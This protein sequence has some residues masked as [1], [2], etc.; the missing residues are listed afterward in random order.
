MQ[1]IDHEVV[2]IGGLGYVGSAMT[3][4]FNS[5]GINVTIIDSNIY[6][7]KLNILEGNQYLNIDIRSTKDL[8]SYDFK[9]KN[10]IVLSGL[11]GDPITNKYPELSRSINESSL[12]NFLSSVE[13]YKKLIF[14]STCSNYGLNNSDTPLNEESPLNPI[15]L[16]AKSKVAV[17]NFLINSN[18]N[19]IILRFAT[20]FGH[21]P[22]M[23]F[24]LTL[25]EFTAM[26]YYNKFIEVYD[27]ETSRPYCH[28]KDFARVIKKLISNNYKNINNE[29]FN[30]GSNRNNI[31]KENLIR[32]IA[33]RT[34]NF[35]YELVKESKDKRNYVVDFSKI[36]K[37]LNFLPSF[38]LEEG[39]DEIITKLESDSYDLNK[40][41]EKLINYYGN[42]KIPDENLT[43]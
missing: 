22:N 25:N 31:S 41:F 21:S 38:D 28:V 40:N 7:K 34:N 2:L 9:A 26:L 11:V 37:T 15:S 43:N 12:I 17:E 4:F 8:L 10:I 16:Y 18:K 13:E 3:E 42:Y 6:N 33:E 1:N 19:Y 24:D 35:N 29:V 30:V 27:Y 23:R 5:E 14:I 32:L 36:E 20:A 39:I